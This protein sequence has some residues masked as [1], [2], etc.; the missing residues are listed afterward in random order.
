M[1]FV[2]AVARIA[3]EVLE[4]VERHQRLGKVAL[5]LLAPRQRQGLLGAAVRQAFQFLSGC[6]DMFCVFWCL[7]ESFLG[8]FSRLSHLRENLKFYILCFLVFAYL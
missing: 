5:E 2:H 3:V 4:L 7:S 6:C 8:K 1:E